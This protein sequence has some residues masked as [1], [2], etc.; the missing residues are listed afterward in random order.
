MS[1]LEDLLVSEPYGQ[2]GRRQGEEG[3]CSRLITRL[4]ISLQYGAFLPCCFDDGQK[5]PRWWEEWHRVQVAGGVT[6]REASGNV[7]S[8]VVHWAPDSD[9]G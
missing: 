2:K 5:V 8:S 1:W 9:V 7:K 4:A 3:E 6:Q